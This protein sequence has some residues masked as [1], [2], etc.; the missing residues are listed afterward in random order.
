[1]ASEDI[2]PSWFILHLIHVLPLLVARKYNNVTGS[3]VTQRDQ[4]H[5]FHAQCGSRLSP[6][7]LTVRKAMPCLYSPH[8]VRE[9]SRA[10]PL[11]H[12]NTET[13]KALAPDTR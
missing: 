11:L 8:K 1:M 10:L 2:G 12:A 13:V 9:R 4:T 3:Y 7:E 6:G 5:C